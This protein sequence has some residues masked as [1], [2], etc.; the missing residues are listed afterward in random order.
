MANYASWPSSGLEL[1][2]LLLY[3]D[4]RDTGL[5]L[6]GTQLH[7]QRRVPSR[8]LF[9][10]TL[11]CQKCVWLLSLKSPKKILFIIPLP[12]VAFAS[13]WYSGRCSMDGSKASIAQS[14]KGLNWPPGPCFLASGDSYTNSAVLFLSSGPSSR[15]I[16][17]RRG[18]QLCRR[19][20]ASPSTVAV[21]APAANTASAANNIVV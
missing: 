5:E 14:A 19:N 17:H 20:C 13:V 12:L 4:L 11:A 18:L 8:P 9:S 16:L 21:A 7:E 1:F 3:F 2:F 10:R 6:E 15:V